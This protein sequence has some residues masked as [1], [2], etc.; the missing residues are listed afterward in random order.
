MAD[1]DLTLL[2]RVHTKA[3][4]QIKRLGRSVSQRRMPRETEKPPLTMIDES[5]LMEQVPA[6]KNQDG[7]RMMKS[8]NFFRVPNQDDESK[9]FFVKMVME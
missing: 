2:E 4:S 6:K 5:Q 1:I 3:S 9:I 8:E 7:Q